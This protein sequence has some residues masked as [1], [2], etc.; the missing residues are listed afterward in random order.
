MQPSNQVSLTSISGEPLGVANEQ[1]RSVFVDGAGARVELASGETLR[2]RESV[3]EVYR[4]RHA[5]TGDVPGL[6][7]REKL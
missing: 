5:I 1:I 7:E 2:V 4:K 3:A 6:I